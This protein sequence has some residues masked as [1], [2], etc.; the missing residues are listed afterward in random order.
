MSTVDYPYLLAW[1]RFLGSGQSYYEQER[2]LARADGAP[3]DVIYAATQ[4]QNEAS[5]RPS[6]REDEHT[7]WANG[8]VWHRV[9][10]ITIE[11]NK[12]AIEAEVARMTG[13]EPT[14][15]S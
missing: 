10:G 13:A 5:P 12:A 6:T 1:C 15:G 11:A 4:E 14:D 8:R 9:G 3:Q 2:D 7:F